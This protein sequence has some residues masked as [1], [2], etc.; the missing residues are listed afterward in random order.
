MLL[1]ERQA[2]NVY[3]MYNMT[4]VYYSFFLLFAKPLILKLTNT[5]NLIEFL[6]LYYDW[7]Y[8][9]FTLTKAFEEGGEPAACLTA[10]HPKA[11]GQGGSGLGRHRH[12]HHHLLCGTGQLGRGKKRHTWA[13]CC[14][15]DCASS[16]VRSRSSTM[17]HPNFWGETAHH[18]GRKPESTR[19]GV[20]Q[21]FPFCA[22]HV[23]YC[24]YGTCVP[25]CCGA[26]CRSPP[27]SVGRSVHFQ[28]RW[29]SH[30][31]PDSRLMW[32]WLSPASASRHPMARR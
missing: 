29:H 13:H 14:H 11:C 3:Y 18:L 21:C 16:N 4:C 28:Q 19:G 15:M 1:L 20:T 7:R 25:Y 27:D 30:Y 17:L 2:P 8:L 32:S 12:H 6:S 24:W 10:A 5:S 26:P 31:T 23:P 9:A 22:C